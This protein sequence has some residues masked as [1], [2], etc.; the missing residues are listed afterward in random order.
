MGI[1]KEFKG[2]ATYIVKSPLPLFAKESRK[3]SGF[4]KGRLG[5]I[6]QTMLSHLRTC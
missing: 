6:F 2:K 4:G 3:R 1:N 5:G